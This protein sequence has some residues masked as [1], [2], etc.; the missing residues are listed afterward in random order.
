MEHLGVC[1]GSGKR[2]KKVKAVCRGLMPVGTK[3]IGEVRVIFFM[4][5]F[6]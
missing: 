6:H 2:Q 3:R 4:V 1:E 5:S